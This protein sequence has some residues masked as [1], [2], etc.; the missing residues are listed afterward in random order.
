MY[1]LFNGPLDIGKAQ[2]L[3]GESRSPSDTTASI[4]EYVS[5]AF[6]MVLINTMLLTLI[7]YN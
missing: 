7:N 3:V 5:D 2:S 4:G 6:N 1:S